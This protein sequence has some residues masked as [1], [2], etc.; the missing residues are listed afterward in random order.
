MGLHRDLVWH[1][2]RVPADIEAVH[3]LH[4]GAQ[5]VTAEI[6]TPSAGAGKPAQE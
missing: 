2:V 3:W 5:E 4:H 1:I 6:F